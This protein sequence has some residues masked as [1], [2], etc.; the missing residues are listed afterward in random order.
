MN[1]VRQLAKG[2][3]AAVLPRERILMRGP[4]STGRLPRIALTFDD[5]PHPVHT[6]VLL[7]R[8]AQHQLRATFFVI[9]ENARR[10]S[11]LVARMHS[12]G[13]EIGNHTW[14][15]TEPKLT[16][17]T[18]LADEIR[19]TDDLL[20]QLT[21]EVPIMMRPP[22]GEVGT[23]KLLQLWKLRKTVAMWNVD[24]KDFRMKSRD[25]MDRWCRAYQPTD[26]DIVL[27]HDNHPYAASAIENFAEEDLFGQFEAVTLSTWL[28]LKNS[29]NPVEMG[30]ANAE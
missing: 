24:P 19:R 6:P 29:P 27:M 22:K 14:S 9:G 26:G 11:D 21:G 10:Y 23:Q 28:N 17:T 7:D 8:L 15:H 12:D 30:V 3:L 16:T 25:E 13:H 2:L 20:F 5:G 4:K 18:M 1:V